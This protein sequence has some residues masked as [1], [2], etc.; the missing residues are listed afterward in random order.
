MAS[1]ILLLDYLNIDIINFSSNK[2]VD[3]NIE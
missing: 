1:V 2:E 3:T